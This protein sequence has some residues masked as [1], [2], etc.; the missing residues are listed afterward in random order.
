VQYSC[1][2][3]LDAKGRV[4]VHVNSDEESE[5]ETREEDE[6]VTERKEPVPRWGVLA[7]NKA[8]WEQ[9]CKQLGFG[10][11]CFGLV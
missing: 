1:E 9:L 2:T 6:F 8:V 5:A 11:W 4:D 10:G 7:E 3:K